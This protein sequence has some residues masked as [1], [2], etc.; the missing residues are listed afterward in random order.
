MSSAGWARHN[1]L[2]AAVPSAPTVS[3]F[4]RLENVW[5]KKTKKQAI[6]QVKN[7]SSEYTQPD[8][9]LKDLFKY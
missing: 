2:S 1:S 3:S 8:L 6:K 9:A 4:S 5:G 7:I